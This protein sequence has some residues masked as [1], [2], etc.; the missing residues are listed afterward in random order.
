MIEKPLD[1]GDL[2]ASANTIIYLGKIRDGNKFRR[3]M[4]VAKHRGNVCPDDILYYE[5]DDH[6]LWLLPTDCGTFAVSR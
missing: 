1:E 2:L 3:A 6:G 5:T 4:H